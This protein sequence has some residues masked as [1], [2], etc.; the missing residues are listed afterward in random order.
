MQQKSYRIRSY[1]R[2]IKRQG[3]NPEVLKFTMQEFSEERMVQ[4]AIF[5]KLMTENFYLLKENMSPY[6]SV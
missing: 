5:A 1:E 4:Q 6:E 3:I 2:K